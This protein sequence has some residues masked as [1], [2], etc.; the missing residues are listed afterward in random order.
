MIGITRTRRFRLR[1]VGLATAAAS[2]ILAGAA[3][4]D[5]NRARFF[6]MSSVARQELTESLRRFDSELR[7]DQQQTVRA[8]NDRL[9]NLPTE[10]RDKYLIVLR[11]YHNWLADLPEQIREDFLSRPSDERLT[12]MKTLVQKYPLPHEEARSPL[13]FIQIGGTG[14]FELASLCKIW[15]EITPLDRKKVDELPA[16]NRREELLRLGRELKI[17]RELSP[18]DYQATIWVAKAEARIK[19]LRG[20]AT[21]QNDWIGKL[22]NRINEATERNTDGKERVPPFLHRLAVN[23]YVQEHKPTHPVD[24]GRLFRFL[25]DMPP[26]IRSTFHPLASDEARKRLTLVYRL[27]F[28][29]PQEFETLPQGQKKHASPKSS[30]PLKPAPSSPLTPPVPPTTNQTPF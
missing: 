9:N 1:S 24:P 11:R 10:D 15:Q 13:D 2:L 30:V 19:E 26:W 29:Y 4:L 27:V 22:E 16:G 28:P 17:P 6:Q 5:G 25:G 18:H 23:L 12:R 3:S 21:N 7:P 8:I 14:V 20:P